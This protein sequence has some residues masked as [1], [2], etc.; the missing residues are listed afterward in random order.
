MDK[1]ECADSEFVKLG[2]LLGIKREQLGL[3]VFR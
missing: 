1:F 2:S 3:G